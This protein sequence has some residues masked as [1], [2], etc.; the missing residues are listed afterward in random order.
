MQFKQ[1]LAAL[2]GLVFAASAHTQAAWPA[3]AVTLVVPFAAGGPTDVVAR[4]L[5]ASMSKTLGQTVVVENKLGAGG[6]VAAGSVAKS[7]PDGYTFFIHHNGMATSTALYRK[8]SYDPLNDFEFVSQAVDVPMTMLARKDFPAANLQEMVAYIKANKDKINVATAG[9]GAVSQLCGMLFQRAI[10]VQLTEV[11]FQGTA[12]AMNALLGGQVD[13]LCDQTTQTIPQIK[14]GNVKLYGVTTKN[15]IK[16][17]PNAPTLAEQGLKDFEVV[18]WHGIYAPKG[19]PKP[20]IERMNAAVRAALKDPDVAKRMEDLG[21]EIVPDSKLSPEGLQS[22]LK[23]EIDKWGP[24]I[25]AGG[26]F[27]D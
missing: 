7:P 23:S 12:P 10:G 6:T 20:I 25:K 15:R 1:A 27:A 21:A 13:V 26:K 17:L 5:A 9:L 2:A 11:P 8:L 4:T 16:S 18:V 3:K 22:W 24:I 14:A 19:T